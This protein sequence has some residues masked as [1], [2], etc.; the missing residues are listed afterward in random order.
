VPVI[1]IPIDGEAANAASVQEAMRVPADFIAHLMASSRP[2]LPV[3]NNSAGGGF[4]SP[5]YTSFGGTVTPS[6]STHTSDGTRFIIKII[7]GGAVGVATFKTSIDGGT[8]FGATQTTAASMTDVT[9]GITLAFVGTLTIN[10]TASFRSAFTPLAQWGDTAGNARSII[11]HLGYRRGRCNEFY[12]EW[13][14]LQSAPATGAGTGKFTRY[15]YS[16]P[17][18]AG[19]SFQTASAGFPGGG[20]SIALTATPSGNTLSF[21]S[22]P[23]FYYQ[24]Y[25]SLV[26][27]LEA[28]FPGGADG[29]NWVVGMTTST[30]GT[31]VGT[32]P[33]VAFGKRSTD[34]TYQLFTADGATLTP[35]NTTITPAVPTVG[36]RI[37]LELHGS[38]TPYGSKARLII[39]DNV[40]ETMLNLPAVA[41][42]MPF[43]IGGTTIGT[44]S[45]Q[46]RVSPIRITWNR[47]LN[48]L[49]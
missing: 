5:S 45:T 19:A 17:T 2:E 35:T 1:Q 15:N 28:V 36:D 23:M 25:S 20:A 47:A 3:V 9:S 41:T 32:T 46:L 21:Q 14:S 8:T 6:G 43:F 13:T 39:N 44:A 31:L 22:P 24:T 48:M 38:A 18:G 49:P 34:T 4:T 42:A 40:T 16:F 12:E 27:E 26:M 10:G 33:T 11:D 7:A 37:I 29:V 30:T